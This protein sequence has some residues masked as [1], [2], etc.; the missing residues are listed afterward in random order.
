MIEPPQEGNGGDCD[1]HTHALGIALAKEKG[2]FVVNLTSEHRRRWN[3][4]AQAN[5]LVLSDV[6]DPDF[7]PLI[8]ERKDQG[9]IT[10]YQ[11]TNGIS[12]PERSNPTHSLQDEEVQSLIRRLASFCDSLQVESP[13]LEEV[14]G[15]LN[16]ICRLFPKQVSDLPAEQIHLGRT[17]HGNALQDPLEADHARERIEFYRDLLLKVDGESRCHH[18]S[19]AVN[20]WASM[21]GAVVTGRHIRL[22]P[23]K[24]ELLLQQ[25]LAAMRFPENRETAS[26]LFRRAS[27]VEPENE[28]PYLY[29]APVSATPVESLLK[30]VELNPASLRA[31]IMLGDTLA[32]RGNPWEAIRWFK[33]A[34]ELFPQ[35]EISCQKAASI[36][37]Q[38]G[39]PD[40]AARLLKTT[41]SFLAKESH[42]VASFRLTPAPGLHP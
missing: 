4:A 24:F 29:G 26:R 35:Y 39:R 22:A 17:E 20:G 13:R 41:A 9:K 27:A 36:L 33:T 34:V 19:E 8:R 5:V 28:L 1:H 18:L 25:G 10:I 32:G 30:A 6:C 3:I 40:E 15:H 42:Q 38:I 16:P 23:T 11:I 14:Y 31:R 7:L 37:E 2:V 21:D 12:S